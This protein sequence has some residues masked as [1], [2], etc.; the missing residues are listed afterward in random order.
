M[1]DKHENK[2][3]HNTISHHYLVCYRL[4]SLNIQSL[5]MGHAYQ[6]RVTAS[7]LYGYG[8]PSEPTDVM[9]DEESVKPRKISTQETQKRGKNIKVDDYDK[10][11]KLAKKL[12]QCYIHIHFTSFLKLKITVKQTTKIYT[13]L[14]SYYAYCYFVH[15]CR[16][17]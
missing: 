14:F 12:I 16:V 7:N 17:L 11:C 2:P 3:P 1:F 5:V 8:A 6:L 9:L 15:L 13:A 4:K 10:F